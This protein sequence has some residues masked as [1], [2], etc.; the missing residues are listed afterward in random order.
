[1]KYKPCAITQA[2]ENS[3]IMTERP[4]LELGRTAVVWVKAHALPAPVQVFVFSGF[5]AH[6]QKKQRA[7]EKL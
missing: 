1:M 3:P 2:D 5:G 6:R 4:N 7:C